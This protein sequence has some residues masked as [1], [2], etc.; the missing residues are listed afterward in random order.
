MSRLTL[1]ELIERKRQSD[2]DKV[3]YKAVHS[4]LLGG[5]IMVKKLPLRQVTALVDRFPDPNTTESMEMM[6]ELI[7][8]SCDLFRSAELQKEYGIEGDK[9][10][11]VSAVFE[12]NLDEITKVGQEILDFYFTNGMPSIAE[13]KNS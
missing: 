8:R 9:Y 3:K 7:Y 12:D 2:D 11:I 1:E 13:L 10:E 6:Q 5:E 4:D